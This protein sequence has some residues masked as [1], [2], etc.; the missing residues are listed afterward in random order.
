[1][2]EVTP[3]IKWFWRHCEWIH[4]SY[5]MV[6][7]LWR[8]DSV[9]ECTLLTKWFPD[10]DGWVL[11]VNALL[12]KWFPGFDGWILCVNVPFLPNCSLTMTAGFCVNV[13]LSPNGSLAMTAGFC[14]WMYPSYQMVPRLW[15]L[16]SVCE[17]T[18]LSKWFPGYDGW[19]LCVSVPLLLN[20]SL[21]M[22]A[23]FCVWMYPSH[24]MVPRPSAGFCVWMYPSH[25]MVPWLWRLGSVC[26]CTPLTKWF[27][28]YDGWVLCVNV[29]LLSNGSPAMTAGFC[30]WMYPSHQMVPRPSAG[31]CVWMYPSHQMVPWLWRLGSVCECTPLTKWFPDHR[32]G[33]VCECTPLTKWFPGY[34]GWVLCVNVP[35]VLNGSLAMTAGF[36]VWMYPSHQMVPRLRR[37]G[38]VCEC[39]PLIKWFPGYDGW[40]LCVNHDVYNTRMA[41][42]YYWQLRLISRCRHPDCGQ[43]LIPLQ[44]LHVFAH[45]RDPHPA[46]KL[47]C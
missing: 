5:Q 12:I 10:Y 7:W 17:C 18:P 47:W 45:S 38:S 16:G 32:L 30:V 15:R 6:P 22:T 39:T 46:I 24:Q 44:R 37:L 42:T 2:C 11:C 25:Q 1:M 43:D 14:V 29:P 31:F 27:P 8:L 21:A 36:C 40:V 13:P 4:P 33:S 41:E 3:P 28:D 23:G 9:C 34:D 19:V 20:G 26:E 35:F